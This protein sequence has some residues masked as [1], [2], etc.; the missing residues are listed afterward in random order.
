M[1][2]TCKIC[3]ATSDETQF[4]AGVNSRCAECHKA[5]VRKN[6]A[7]KADYYRS[8]DAHRYQNDPRVKARHRRYAKTEAGKASRQK[9][10]DKWL[11]ASPEK[12]AAHIILGNAVRDGKINKP[13]QCEQCGKPGRIDGHHHDYTQPLNVKWLCKYCHVQEHR[14]K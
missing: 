11:K 8:Y 10:R 13:K 12:R 3:G 2:H 1:V 4:Y 6:R 14:I 5:K 7:E 9:A